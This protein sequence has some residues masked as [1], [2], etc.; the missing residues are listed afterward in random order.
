M[1]STVQAVSKERVEARINSV[2]NQLYADNVRAYERA[3]V[4]VKEVKP[5]TLRTMQSH[6]YKALTAV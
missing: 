4:E 6:L 5:V 3:A 2:F 1:V